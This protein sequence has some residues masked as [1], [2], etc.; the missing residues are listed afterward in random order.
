MKTTTHRGR[1]HRQ[2]HPHCR[3]ASLQ[4]LI[5]KS[6]SGQSTSTFVE[7]QNARYTFDIYER[8]GPVIVRIDQSTRR[9]ECSL[10]RDRRPH[11]SDTNRQEMP[12]GT[13]SP[14]ISAHAGAS[15]QVESEISLHRNTTLGDFGFQT[16]ELV[17]RNPVHESDVKRPG[18]PSASTSVSVLCVL[19]LCQCYV[20]ESKPLLVIA[21][22]T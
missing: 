17:H 13:K 15:H 22:V 2:R 16:N 20:L 3:L 11:A 1:E 10:L 19:K 5:L 9:F 8:M 7:K 4:P 21:R 6:S 18:S 12:S 14:R